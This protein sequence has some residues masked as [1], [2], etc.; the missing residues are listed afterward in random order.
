VEL[1]VG[2][3]VVGFVVVDVVEVVGFVVVGGEVGVVKLLDED[4]LVVEVLVE[5]VL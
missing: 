1:V 4:V 5:L 3:G 2:G